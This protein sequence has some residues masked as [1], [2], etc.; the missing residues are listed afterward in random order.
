MRF[1]LRHR[2][3][4]VL[5]SAF[6]L[7]L[8]VAVTW[9]I[10]QARKAQASAEELRQL[11]VKDLE[12]AAMEMW[13]TPNTVQR[14]VQLRQK[15]VELMRRLVRDEPSSVQLKR[16]MLSALLYCGISLGYTRSVNLGQSAE[17]RAQFESA[18]SLAEG[19]HLS[20][21]H[22]SPQRRGLG[23]CARLHGSKRR[24]SR[25]PARCKRVPNE[26][27]RSG[28]ELSINGGSRANLE[29]RKRERM[30]SLKW[31]EYLRLKAKLYRL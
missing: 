2:I 15:R 31:Q 3:P 12:E 25:R 8:V 22:R 13:R 17:S 7:L 6:L 26:G 18:L 27:L 4:F 16:E 1:I 21:S 24:R 19:L 9:V 11:A 20:G 5:G 23:H 10:F 14:V 29:V 28:R 30:R